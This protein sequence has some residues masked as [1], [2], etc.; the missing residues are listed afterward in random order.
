MEK[1]GIGTDASIPVHITNIKERGYVVEIDKKRLQPTSLG[2]MLVRG[3]LEIDPEL[4]L[5][6]VRSN[7][8]K[9]VMLIAKVNSYI[10]I[11]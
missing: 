4:V 7:I 1:F 3:Y 5:P 6:S 11:N 10:Y 2:R 8:E 9:S